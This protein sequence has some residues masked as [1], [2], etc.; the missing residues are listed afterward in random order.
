MFFKSN[1]IWIT[2][3]RLFIYIKPYMA[4]LITMVLCILLNAATGI[5]TPIAMKNIL[6]IVFSQQYDMFPGIY[7]YILII[8]TAI[9]IVASC[10]NT[11]LSGIF[12]TNITRDIRNDIVQ[13]IQRVPISFVYN[14]EIG[15]MVSRFDS[16]V[17][18]ITGILNCLSYL[19]YQPL[20]FV[21]TIVVA[22]IISWKLLLSV[23]IFL[24]LFIKMN[25]VIG[26]P[27]CKY[28]NNIQKEHASANSIIQDTIES[29][30]IIKAFNIKDVFSR[31]Y[32][33]ILDQIVFWE[34]KTE[35]RYIFINIFKILLTVLP[36]VLISY[37]GG[38]LILNKELTMG[39]FIIYL[40]LINYITG[41]IS[42][43]NGAI[44]GI[45]QAQGAL[46]RVLDIL[47]HP[48]E[49]KGDKSI[50][51][52]EN[53]PAIMFK[54][55]FFSYNNE[56]IVLKNLSFSIH[57]GSKVAFVGTSGSGKSTIVNLLCRFYEI[58]EGQIEL[59]GNNIRE[60]KIDDI[61]SNISMVLQDTYIFPASIYENILYGSPN[62]TMEEVIKAAKDAN[63]HEFI[64]QFKDGYK[65]IVGESG[66]KLSG[67]QKQRIT[68]ARALLKKAPLLILDEPSSALDVESETLINDTLRAIGKGMT[69]LIIAHKL[70]SIKKVDKIF[71]LQEGA[72]VETGTHDE[73]MEI[74]GVYNGLY[75]K[76]V[77]S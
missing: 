11:L 64:I 65:T 44:L 31:K 51:I 40:T 50:E 42:S 69:I 3:K 60:L 1:D 5:V 76:T 57:Q 18:L 38:Y 66:I 68:I 22:S 59:Y 56:N 35:K 28:S 33:F 7:F 8:S 37:F 23:V 53:A 55:V 4:M 16:D 75:K 67:G 14:K 21:S 48:V 62:A 15:D 6:D 2:Y 52:K 61:R 10:L 54:D 63:A 74:K 27:F 29:I 45:R 24:P 20:V 77:C 47:N 46:I 13:R 71:V 34:M 58:T 25:N 72:I 43:I 41:P 49:R 9:N 30:Y 39:E 36:I 32:K 73:L 19:I 70:S 17:S 26:K 12:S